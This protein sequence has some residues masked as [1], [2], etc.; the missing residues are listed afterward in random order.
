MSFVL[1]PR[2]M[3]LSQC[4]NIALFAL[5]PIVIAPILAL[6]LQA[7]PPASHWPQSARISSR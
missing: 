4:I 5:S 3:Q 7:W 1:S 2:L 6:V